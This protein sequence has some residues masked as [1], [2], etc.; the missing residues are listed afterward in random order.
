M[1]LFTC[2][3][4]SWALLKIHQVAL[5]IHYTPFNGPDV[6]TNTEGGSYKVLMLIL[7][8][9]QAQILL[10]CDIV[11]GRRNHAILS[12]HSGKRFLLAALLNQIWPDAN[13]Q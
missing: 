7:A 12:F 9:P 10:A 4:E 2:S 8:H 1:Y 13:V 3:C 6:C 11:L 5:L